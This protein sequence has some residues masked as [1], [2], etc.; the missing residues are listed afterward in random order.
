MRTDGYSGAA[1]HALTVQATDNFRVTKVSFGLYAPDGGLLEE[2][3]AVM[4]ENGFDWIYTTKSEIPSP[5]GTL[6]RVSAE[7]VPKNRTLLEV[8]I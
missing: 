4:D 6:I 5:A 7:D 1:G 8:V 3:D 2:G